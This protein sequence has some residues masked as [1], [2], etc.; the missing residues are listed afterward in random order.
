MII[1]H[2]T[3]WEFNPVHH[4]SYID[5]FE[6]VLAETTDMFEIEAKYEESYATDPVVCAPLPDELR[7]PRCPPAL[8]VVL[9][10]PRPSAPRTRDRGRRRPGGRS[11]AGLLARLHAR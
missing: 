2:P 1:S 9:V 7:L 6:Q 4:P 5:F 10:R 11:P 3:P 8:H